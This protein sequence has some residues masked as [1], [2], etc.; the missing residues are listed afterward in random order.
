LFFLIIFY[1][2]SILRDF[3][4]PM[5]AI[6][7]YAVW[8]PLLFCFTAV[9]YYG[10]VIYSTLD[11]LKQNIPVDPTF[12]PPVTIL[13][14]LC[15]IDKNFYEILSSFCRQNYPTYQIVFGVQDPNDPSIAVVK[16]LM[17][18][19]PDVDIDLVISDR[20]IGQNLKVSNLANAA[21]LAKHPLLLSTDSDIRVGSDYLMTVVQPLKDPSVGVVTCLYRCLPQGL[22]A[23]F[24]AL[25]I[26][27]DNHPTILVSRKLG[28][29]SFGVG[30]TLLIRQSVLASVGGFLAVADYLQD[31]FAL[32]SLPSKAGHGVVLSNYVVEHELETKTASDFF[33]QLLRWNIGIRAS[34]PWG[35]AGQIFTYGV[36]ASLLFL[37]AM[38]GTSL[39]WSVLSVIWLLRVVMA[40]VVG[41]IALE[42]PVVKRYWW[43]VPLSDVVR[44]G[45]WCA[46]FV[47]NRIEWRGRQLQL[48]KDGKLI[49]LTDKRPYPAQS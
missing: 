48:T 28:G 19:F 17:Q 9:I 8:I 6:S 38:Q 14:P 2:A 13:K 39:G 44:F 16:Q 35:Y 1:S 5:L 26:S 23:L 42:D 43:L 22:F 10:L 4:H 33:K 41:V 36:V 15:G 27:T 46:A 25:A 47:S 32:G 30:A 11:F 20:A 21:T 7:H 24:V 29:M 40:W 3:G 34:H 45:L 12:H 37:L 49:A 31:D 18:D